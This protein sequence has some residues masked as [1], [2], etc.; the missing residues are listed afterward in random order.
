M[1]VGLIEACFLFQW[2]VHLVLA[3]L[4]KLLFI[5]AHDCLPSTPRFILSILLVFWY[6]CAC[7][8]GFV[9]MCVF[10]CVCVCASLHVVVV[11]Y[12]ELEDGENDPSANFEMSAA[13]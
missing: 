11:G 2:H 7:I 5:S 8:S 13:L 9:Y 12:Q 3:F 1:V 10:V 4:N 6:M